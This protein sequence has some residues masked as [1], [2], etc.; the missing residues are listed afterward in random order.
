MSRTTDFILDCEARGELEYDH[1]SRLYV[2][3]KGHTK[4]T[5]EK[6]LETATTGLLGDIR[7]LKEL[8]EKRN[9]M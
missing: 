4:G 9:E 8:L 1:N 3:T 7:R 2:T 6:E 5:L